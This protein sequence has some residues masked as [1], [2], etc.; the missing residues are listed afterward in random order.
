M[1]E[2]RDYDAR[3]TLMWAGM[4]SHNGLM[5]TGRKYFMAAHRLQH[6]LS[7]MNPHVAH[8]AGLAVIWPAYL[9]YIYQYDLPG[10]CN[11]LWGFGA[12]R[13]MI[14]IRRPRPWPASA[15]RRHIFGR[16]ACYPP[17]RAGL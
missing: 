3:A 11:T 5:G 12:V 9:K 10:L 2:P 6:E 8:G 7:A 17:G 15:K 14:T 4:L 1:A 13:R 16:S